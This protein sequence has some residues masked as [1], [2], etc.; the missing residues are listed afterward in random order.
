MVLE[1]AMIMPGDSDASA[2]PSPKSTLSTAFVSETHIQITSAP[3]EASA[4][5]DAV[6][7]PST[8]LP[9]LRFHTAT[10]CPALTRLEAIECPIIP[11]PR[12]ASRIRFGPSFP[13]F[14]MTSSSFSSD[15]YS[16]FPVQTLGTSIRNDHES[17]GQGQPELTYTNEHNS[18]L[19]NTK[20]P[21]Q[22]PWGSQASSVRDAFEGIQ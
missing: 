11:R 20:R 14:F 1:S 19:H 4:G 8:S 15:F 13:T 17:N 16:D 12:N 6:R 5:D 7:A 18:N 21:Q 10:S 22:F 3:C 2:P 9:A